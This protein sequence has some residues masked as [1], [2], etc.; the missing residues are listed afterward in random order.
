VFAFTLG[1]LA[2]DAVDSVGTDLLDSAEQR[3]WSPV[4]SGLFHFGCGVT[5]PTRTR[6]W[7]VDKLPLP[8]SKERIRVES[9]LGEA[10]A[11]PPKSCNSTEMTYAALGK[12]YFYHKLFEKLMPHENKLGLTLIDSVGKDKA[13]RL[14]PCEPEKPRPNAGEEAKKPPCYDGTAKIDDLLKEF[15]NQLF[16]NSKNLIFLNQNYFEELTSLG[17]R[18]DL[19]RSLT[20][21]AMVFLAPFVFFFGPIAFILLPGA[22]ARPAGDGLRNAILKRAILA[23]L[24]IPALLFLLY[25]ARHAYEYEQEQFTKRVFGYTSTLALLAAQT[26]Q[27]AAMEKYLLG[28][29]GDRE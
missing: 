8:K 2:Q 10:A 4:E 22:L 27:A 29:K 28:I 20:Y 24:A 9:L 5:P 23:G 17:R 19:A 26:G 18:V 3:Q 6:N 12:A 1:F 16:Y 21:I 11:A 15:I 25:F 14:V 7:L 13:V